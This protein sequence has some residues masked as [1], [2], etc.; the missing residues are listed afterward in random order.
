MSLAPGKAL[1]SDYQRE[2][3][4]LREAGAEFAGRYP[5]IARRLALDGNECPDPHVE[6]LLEGFA[7]LSARLAGRLN[8]GYRQLSNAL[9]EQLYPHATRPIPSAAIVRFSPDPAKGSLAEGYVIPRATPLYAVTR[10]GETIRFLTTATQTLWPVSVADAHLLSAEQAQAVTGLPQ[11]AAALRI[12][13]ECH[14]P[15][16]WDELPVK[17][18]SIHLAG[19]PVQRMALY[20]LLAAHAIGSCRPR[21][22]GFDTDELLL[23][24][25][26]GVDPAYTLLREYF[27]FPE[28]F[29]FFDLPLPVHRPGGNALEIVIAFDRGPDQPLTVE[30]KD[31]ALGCVPVVN[32]FS[33]ISDPLRFDGTVSEK[34]LSVGTASARETEIYRIDRVRA[35]RNSQ[36][37][38]I[39]PYFSCTAHTPGGLFWY[40]RRQDRPGEADGTQMLLSFADANFD[41]ARPLNLSLTAE[42]LCTNGR[43]AARLPSGC[44]L[45]FE[46]PGPVARVTLLHA[47]TEAGSAELDGVS[48]WKLIALVGLGSLPLAEGEQALE[49]LRGLLATH[50]PGENPAAWRQLSGIAAMENRRTVAHLGRDAWRGWCHG[51]EVALTLTPECFVGGS[52]VLFGG[53]LAHVFVRL[54]A[55]N[56]FIH[57]V[58][59]LPG[60]TLAPWPPQPGRQLVL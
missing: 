32:L 50:I 33:C 18:L 9:L 44:P 26:N 20:D 10:S 36:P 28:K 7:F 59:H 13:L 8:D 34:P 5:K 6:R 60:R 42:L 17:R 54:A 25:E 47:P 12:S 56:S 38:N 22:L 49:R 37:E 23:P 58:L 2:L 30:A 51:H 3:A 53:V 39:E 24:E 55:P 21:A 29:L 15:Y 27:A 19:S 31:F 41:P 46:R 35:V 1:L 57:T 11:A 14:A 52:P 4:Y 48:Q 40:A 45:S 43:R 16:R